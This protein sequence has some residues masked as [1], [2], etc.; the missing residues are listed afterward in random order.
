M[1]L[2]DQDRAPL[3]VRE[4][5]GEVGRPFVPAANCRVENIFGG[6]TDI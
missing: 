3:A 2:F 4:T 1:S 5:Q 6:L